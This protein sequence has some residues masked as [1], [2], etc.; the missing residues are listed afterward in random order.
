MGRIGNLGVD[1]DINRPIRLL[2]DRL[3]S[4]ERTFARVIKN[5]S[6][7]AKHSDLQNLDYASSGHT[8]FASQAALT[9]HTTNTSNPHSTTL[10]QAVAANATATSI[11]TLLGGINFGT[12]V[13]DPTS[14][15]WGN[16]GYFK[17]DVP[18]GTWNIQFLF[19]PSVVMGD[20]SNKGIFAVCDYLDRIAIQVV[21]D[22]SGGYGSYGSAVIFPAP[23]QLNN[24][25]FFASA[26]TFASGLGTN[27][28]L[29]TG[30]GTSTGT[31]RSYG[32]A[33]VNYAFTW[34]DGS[35]PYLQLYGAGIAGNY[36]KCLHVWGGDYNTGHLMMGNTV[37]N[38]DGHLWVDNTDGTLCLRAAGVPSSTTDYGFAVGPADLRIK[39]AWNVTLGT[40]TG[41][42]IGG[43]TTQKLGFWNA[44]PVVQPS[45]TGTTAGYSDSGA[46]VVHSAGTFTGNSGATAY[47]IGDIVFNLKQCGILKS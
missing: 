38:K 29:G 46:T 22:A 35:N 34:D 42:K 27:L 36:K 12:G 33:G 18:D 17:S 5:G 19:R 9:A 39:D 30:N 1:F 2:D 32:A 7:V 11:P 23:V 10:Q 31:V 37:G 47:T 14:T 25:V 8:G 24:N 28:I 45:T 43:A 13:T 16:V 21:A 6:I 40:T 4:M 20:G 44:T 15:G 3:S 26:P 41:T